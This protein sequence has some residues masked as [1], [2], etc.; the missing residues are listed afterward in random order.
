[1]LLQALQQFVRPV[2]SQPFA[3]GDLHVDGHLLG[4]DG[5]FQRHFLR[6]LLAVGRLRLLSKDR[7]KSAAV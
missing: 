2:D 1:M 3:F 5:V 6:P 7:E 4:S